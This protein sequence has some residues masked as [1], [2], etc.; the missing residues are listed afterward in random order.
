MSIGD[1]IGSA[2]ESGEISIPI[3]DELLIKDSSDSLR[4]LVDFVSK[5]FAKH[6]NLRFFQERWI[7]APT[8]DAVVHVNEFLLSLV[9]GDEKEYISFDSD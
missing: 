8:L 3:L 1:G 9:P 4:S 2:N 7:L 5:I 6:E